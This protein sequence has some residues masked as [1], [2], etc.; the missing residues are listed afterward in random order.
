MSTTDDSSI[1]FLITMFCLCLCSGYLAKSSEAQRSRWREQ[2]CDMY[3]CRRETIAR[4]SFNF[5]ATA[6]NRTIHVWYLVKCR[7]RVPSLLGLK[8]SL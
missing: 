4:G 6:G 2:C 3:G 8:M 5:S 1:V 7:N